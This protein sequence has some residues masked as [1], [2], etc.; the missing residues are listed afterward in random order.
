MRDEETGSWWQ[1]VSGEAILGPMKGT[2]LKQVAHD[3]LTVATWKLEQPHGRVLRPDERVAAQYEPADW[4]ERYARAPTVTPAN[5]DDPFLPRELI[6]G[7][8][9]GEESKA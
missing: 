6:I 9:I 1:Q 5:P 7:I 8:S 3:E 4:E 2:R